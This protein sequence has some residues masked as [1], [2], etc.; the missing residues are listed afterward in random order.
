MISAN[1][2][3]RGNFFIF[4][5]ARDAVDRVRNFFEKMSV[6]GR[7]PRVYLAPRGELLC[8]WTRRSRSTVIPV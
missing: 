2:S 4:D 3:S 1:F 6:T 8:S 5:S 7:R